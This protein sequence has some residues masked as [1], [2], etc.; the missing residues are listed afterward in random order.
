MRNRRAA[1][2]LAIAAA[3]IFALLPLN[4][5]GVH[6]G[7]PDSGH[8]KAHQVQHHLG[9]GHHGK[10]HG[11]GHGK[12]ELTVMTQNMYLGS[13]LNP[14]LEAKTPEAFVEAVARI[15][16]TVQYTNFPQRAEAIA[17]EIQE[18]DPDLI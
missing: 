14:A 7:G 4:F 17:D 15:Y 16:A 5:A 1:A 13:S 6:R 9:R 10:G 3:L 2:L 11:H 18:Q 8:G 12:R